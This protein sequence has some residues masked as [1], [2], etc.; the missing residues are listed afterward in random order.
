MQYS[1]F[2]NKRIL[3]TGGSGFIGSHIVNELIKLNP[4]SIRII[5]NRDNQYIESHDNITVVKGD[6]SNFEFCV[7]MTKDI[8]IVCHQAALASVPKSIDNPILNHSSNVDG[9]FNL[10]HASYVNKVK[11]F[12]Y[13]SSSA[14]YGNVKELPSCEYEN[15]KNIISPYALSK[16]VNDQYANLYTTLYGMETV[17]LRYFNVY[18]ERQD[19]MS[20]YAC[21]VPIFLTKLQNDEQPIIFGDGNKSRDFIYVKDIVDANIKAMTIMQ[22]DEKDVFGQSYNVGSG[23]STKI[24]DIFNKIKEKLNK[25]TEPIFGNERL[26]D[27]NITLSCNLLCEM[28]LG[29]KAKW[30]L[31]VG[32]DET[33]KNFGI[34]KE[35]NKKH[36]HKHEHKHEHKH[37]E[38]NHSHDD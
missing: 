36:D 14:I 5:D 15:H 8:D 9:F 25:D 4:L 18:G 7:D 17:G 29:F 3:V 19:P 35:N 11:R 33:I 27:A 2:D 1:S 26:G 31:D 10:L 20:A 12:V 30:S 21:V 16:Y 37:G 34:N 38:C 22:N 24:I 32:L 13:A 23:V 28:K 6:I